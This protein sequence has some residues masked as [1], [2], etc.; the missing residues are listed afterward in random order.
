[1]SSVVICRLVAADRLF[2]QG[3]GVHGTFTAA[4]PY[5]WYGAVRPRTTARMAVLDP[6]HRKLDGGVMRMG[7]RSDFIS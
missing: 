2:V 1:M 7:D 6:A 4:R 3:S 5:P